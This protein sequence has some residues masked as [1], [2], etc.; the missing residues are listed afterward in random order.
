MTKGCVSLEIVNS[1]NRYK[2]NLCINTFICSNETMKI[3]EYTNIDLN[4]IDAIEMNNFDQE[5]N[6]YCNTISNIYNNDYNSYIVNVVV[7]ILLLLLFII[8]TLLIMYT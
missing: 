3:N 2:C 1:S 4:V 5:N 7:Y 8:L 6:S